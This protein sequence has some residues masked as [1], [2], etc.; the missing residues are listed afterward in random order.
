MFSSMDPNGSGYV[1]VDD[2][3]AYWQSIGLE[4]S[5]DDQN[6]EKIVTEVNRRLI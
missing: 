6:L 4:T 3:V 1:K 2:V 5:H